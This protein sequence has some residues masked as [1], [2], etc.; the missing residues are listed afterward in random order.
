MP[1]RGFFN[2]AVKI[3]L[4][5]FKFQLPAASSIKD[6]LMSAPYSGGLNDR[7]FQN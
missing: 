4:S 2:P 5:V 1:G 7:F 6:I 3:E